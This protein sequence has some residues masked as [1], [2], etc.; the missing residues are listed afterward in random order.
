MKREAKI[1]LDRGVSSL[2][3]SID[4]FNRPWDTGRVEGFL[5]MLDH[6]FEMLLKASI[7][8]KNGSIKERN[9]KYTLGFDACIRKAFSDPD[10][11]FLEEEQALTLQATNN[12]RD[13][14]QHYYLEISEEHLYLHAQSG[15]T[16]FRD[17]L[18]TVFGRN[19]AE[20]LPD[21]VLPIATKLP[22]DLITLFTSE[23][24]E[25]KRLLQPGKRRKAE[26][27]GRLRSLAIVENALN[28]NEDMPNDADLRKLERRIRSGEEMNT[29]FSGVASIKLV[30]E[31]EGPSLSIRIKKKEGIPVQLVPEGTPGASVVAV[32]RVAELD[33]YNLSF[34]DLAGHV[35]LTTNKT[36]AVIWCLDIKNDKNLYKQIVIGKSRFERYSAQAIKAIQDA[37]KET[38]VEEFWKRWRAR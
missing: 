2:I 11:K 15:V 10:I 30:A 36:T 23:V 5:I 3:V 27:L 32:K 22:T 16:L 35:G 37:L 38:T 19:L 7:V 18:Q 33:Y 8:H 25:I 34:A 17:L 29:V 24:D 21:R 1:L 14:A 9:R 28:G 13:A 6:S 12:L 31:G 20:N 4:S 26:A